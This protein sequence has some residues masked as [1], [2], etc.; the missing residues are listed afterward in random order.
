ML[1]SKHRA[2]NRTREHRIEQEIV[3]DAYTEDERALGWYYHLESKL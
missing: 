3:V 2:L 1:E